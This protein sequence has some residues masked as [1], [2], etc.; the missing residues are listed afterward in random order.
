MQSVIFHGS[1]RHDKFLPCRFFTSSSCSTVLYHIARCNCGGGE[2]TLQLFSKH[3][4]F[5]LIVSGFGFSILQAKTRIMKCQQK[6]WLTCTTTLATSAKWRAR[7]GKQFPWTQTCCVN[8][9]L[10]FPALSNE[11]LSGLSLPSTHVE[12]DISNLHSEIFFNGKLTVL[13]RLS[14]KAVWL[15]SSVK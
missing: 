6:W 3:P 12:S 10:V 13:L 1:Q 8:A 5:T 11:Q 2:K 7:N 9:K 14:T 4:H 15:Q